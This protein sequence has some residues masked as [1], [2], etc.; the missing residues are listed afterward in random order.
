[1]R[2]FRKWDIWKE[3]K[4]L[5]TEIYTVTRNFPDEEK[6]GL[7]SQL[8]RATVSIPTNISEGAGRNSEKELL[9]FLH[10]SQG[11]CF[12]VETLLDLSEDLNFINSEV[13][14]SIMIKLNTI[15]KQINKF[16]QVIKSTEGR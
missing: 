14:S 5:V 6:F 11:S 16:I 2:D 10:I 7:I 15:Q 1:M 13:K 8:R 9:H 12:E 4:K 3:S